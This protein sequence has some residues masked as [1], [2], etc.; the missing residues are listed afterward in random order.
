MNLSPEQ[1]PLVV[2]LLTLCVSFLAWRLWLRRH[3]SPTQAR[4]RMLSVGLVLLAV[5][6]IGFAFTLRSEPRNW[7]ALG[8]IFLSFTLAERTRSRLRKQIGSA[9]RHEA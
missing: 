4:Y 5:A 8:L 6:F 3:R 2:L 1:L 9:D 7:V